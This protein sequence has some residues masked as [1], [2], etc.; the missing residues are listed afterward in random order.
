[1]W[2][3]HHSSNP[4]HCGRHG[5]TSPPSDLRP[6]SP[7]AGRYGVGDFSQI[8]FS[9]LSPEGSNLVNRSNLLLWVLTYDVLHSS[10]SRNDSKYS[11]FSSS[12]L[13]PEQ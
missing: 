9:C 5:L 12:T 11:D 4:P 1:M 6:P 2:F 8:P 3:E 10:L 13:N 7:P